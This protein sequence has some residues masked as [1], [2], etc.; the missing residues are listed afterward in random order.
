MS[1]NRESC[2]TQLGFRFGRN[3]PHAARTIM[4]GD[5]QILL[6]SVQADA[7]KAAYSEEVVANNLMGKPTKKAREL[8]LRH[9]AILYGL[10]PSLAVFRVFRRFW[11][12][13]EAARPFLAV[14]VAL[15]RDPRVAGKLGPAMQGVPSG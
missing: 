5:L 8:A 12:L 14:L 7:D 4:F 15:A 1:L 2:L 6:S 9:L 11:S 10:H 13:D 3:G